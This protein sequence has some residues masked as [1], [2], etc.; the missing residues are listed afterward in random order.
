MSKLKCTAIFL[1]AVSLAGCPQRELGIV[2]EAIN[3]SLYHYLN[4]LKLRDTGI[5]DKQG[6]IC[7]NQ[8]FNHITAANTALDLKGPGF[9]ISGRISYATTMQSEYIN[10]ASILELVEATEDCFKKGEVT[11]KFVEVVEATVEKF[12]QEMPQWL[13]DEISSYVKE[14]KWFP[15]EYESPFIQGPQIKAPTQ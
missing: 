1:A 13:Q 3:M 5:I 14:T 2:S 7:I 11:A 15:A 4:E 10:Y 6:I 9:R 12:N 8:N